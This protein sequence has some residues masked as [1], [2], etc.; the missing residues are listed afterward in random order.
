MHLFS[1]KSTRFEVGCVYIMQREWNIEA[2]DQDDMDFE[3]QNVNVPYLEIAVPRLNK[4][5]R[6]EH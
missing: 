2:L 1:Q 6:M 4:I 5:D 3:F